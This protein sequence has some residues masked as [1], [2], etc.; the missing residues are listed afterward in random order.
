MLLS[1]GMTSIGVVIFVGVVVGGGGVVNDVVISAD[2]GKKV[3]KKVSGEVNNRL[4][5]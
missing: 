5:E 1:P 3:I 4:I 2:K